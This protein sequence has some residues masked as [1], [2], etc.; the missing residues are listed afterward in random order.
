VPVNCGAIP[1]NLVESEL[2]GHVRGAF[3][4]AREAKKGLVAQARGGTLFLDELEVMSP[5]AQAAL[6]RFLQDKV[7]RPVGGVEDTVSNIRIIGASNTNLHHLV[8]KGQFRADLLF[9]L[10]VLSVRLP[11]LRDRREDI[12]PLAEKFL[13]RLNRP[14]GQ[15][16][17]VFHPESVAILQAH[18]WPGNVREL[19]NLVQRAF[20]LADERVV[21]VAGLLGG[22]S[23]FDPDVSDETSGTVPVST[24][25]GKA[26][27]NEILTY[28]DFKKAKE[29]MLAELEVSHLTALLRRTRGNLSLASRI[30]GRD[31]SDLCKLLKR[32]GLKRENFCECLGCDESADC[33]ESILWAPW[34][35]PE[36]AT[37]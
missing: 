6:L 10:N 25:P 37:A 15:P 29:N 7:Y 1:D 32:H 17:K 31:R 19:E 30:S 16:A 18:D 26:E 21:R 8:E 20:V 28:G 12:M 24:L 11:P 9:R 4:D 33:A 22:G 23:P 3:T 2:F 13:D 27:G 36:N 35:I 14:S 5:K 34:L